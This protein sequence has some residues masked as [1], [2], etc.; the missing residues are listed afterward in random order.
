MTKKIILILI[1]ALAFF[2]RAY[3]LDQYPP[4]LTWD[5]V[6][7]GYNAYSILKTARDE[8]GV[9][10]PVIFKA[11]GD[12]KLPLQIYLTVPFVAIFGLN[13][14]STRLPGAIVGT[15][16]VLLVYLLCGEFFKDKKFGLLAAFV[17]ALQPYHVIYSRGAWET[18]LCTMLILAALYFFQRF[19]RGGSLW[20]VILPLLLSFYS[21]NAAKLIV[22]LLVISQMI[23]FKDQLPKSKK[24]L[25]PLLTG[26]FL[27][28]YIYLAAFGAAGGRFAVKSFFSYHRPSD[29]VAHLK[30]LDGPFFYALLDNEFFFQLR[31]IADRYFSHLSPRFLFYEG[32]WQSN[33]ARIP[34]Q[35]L[36]YPIDVVLIIL[37]IYFFAKKTSSKFSLTVFSLLLFAP[38]SAAPTLDLVSSVRSH[39]LTIP[40]AILS[41]AGLYWLIIQTKLVFRLFT[42]FIFFIFLFNLI[43]VIDGYTIHLPF[44]NYRAW[45]YGYKQVIQKL[46]VTNEKIVF[47]S[48]LGQPYIYYLFYTQYSPQKFQQEN[49][50]VTTGPDVG[51]VSSLDNLNFHGFD[52]TRDQINDDQIYVGLPEDFQTIDY[53]IHNGVLLGEVR[54]LD[55]SP[56]FAIVKTNKK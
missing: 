54:G 19:L 6:S 25:F 44:E 26:I 22:P 15:L 12:Y 56:Y 49:H 39:L 24:L 23:I 28:L 27:S 8:H 37:G 48:R 18:N 5:E 38:L 10:L 40:L 43:T 50:L 51:F 35:G 9:F 42:I 29:E 14:F 55:N 31:S 17:L 13:D 11:F 53:S 7:I 46:P 16:S 20:L 41:G 47:T 2:L 34:N 36:L 33:F 3:R 21:Y 1:L 4:S 30:Q 32:D 45:L 52:Y